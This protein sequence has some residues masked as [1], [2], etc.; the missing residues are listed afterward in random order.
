MT[1]PKQTLTIVVADRS[2]SMQSVAA[3]MEGGLV[4]FLRD[5]AQ[6]SPNNRVT[7]YQ[8]NVV[9]QCV[10]QNAFASTAPR[11]ELVA[12][13]GTALLDGIGIAVTN[14]GRRLA[15]LPER[16]RPGKVNVLIMTDGFENSSVMWQRSEIRE[17]IERQKTQYGWTFTFMGADQDAITAGADMNIS[18]DTS[19][20]YASVNTRAA[21]ENTSTMISRGNVTGVY[22]YSGEERDQVK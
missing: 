21:W 13:G 4:T 14:E 1:N 16:D 19:L 8:F 9:V 5:R 2:G 7:L 17:L 12:T 10:Y 20:S 15:K 22:A 6:E 18:S 11:F 3:D